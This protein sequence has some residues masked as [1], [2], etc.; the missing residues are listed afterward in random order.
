MKM[1]SNIQMKKIKMKKIRLKKIP[2]S[3]IHMQE[4]NEINEHVCYK[5]KSF[6]L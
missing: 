6:Q 2:K 3:K 5:K 1:I 4:N